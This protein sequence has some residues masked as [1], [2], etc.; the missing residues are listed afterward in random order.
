MK[1]I[2]FAWLR[3]QIGTDSEDIALPSAI[4]TGQDLLSFLKAHGDPYKTALQHG[5]SIGIA[6]D[7]QMISHGDE[8]YNAKEVALFPPMTGG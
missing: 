3:E 2:Y 4:K 6:I 1:I 7:H 5:G 8:I